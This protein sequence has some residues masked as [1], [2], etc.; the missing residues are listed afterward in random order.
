MMIQRRG[1]GDRLMAFAVTAVSVLMLYLVFRFMLF[2]VIGWYDGMNADWYKVYYPA[3]QQADPFVTFGYFN[4]PWLAWLLS[5]LGLLTAVDSHVL[6]IVIILLLTVRCVYA[7]GGGWFAAFL[8]VTSP[9][10]LF[11][12]AHGQIDILVLLGL[13]TGSWLLILIKP[14][15][16]GLAVVYDVIARRRVDWFAVAFAAV[17]LIAFILFMTRPE[18]AGLVTSA[19][20]TPWPWGIPLGIVLFIVALMRRDKWLAALSTF[21][22][23]PYMSGSSVL[24]Y[25]AIGTSRYGRITAIVFS[26]LLWVACLRWFA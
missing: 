25:S 23:A 9:G 7:L 19:S 12:L 8:T 26:V 14:Q 10:F 5:P 3:I 6:W 22:I 11:T 13:L 2:S 20:I 1:A 4:P 18:R 15:V 17:S 21:F 24:V 16:A